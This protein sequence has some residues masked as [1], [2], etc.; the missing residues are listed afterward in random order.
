MRLAGRGET[1][2]DRPP[3]TGE[4][5]PGRAVR[6]GDIVRPARAARPGGG[7]SRRVMT[8]PDWPT[9]SR[10]TAA[11]WPNRVRSTSTSRSRGDRRARG[12][13]AVPAAHAGQVPSSA[14]R[15][16]PG[17]HSGARAAGGL[18]SLPALDVFGVGDDDQVIYQHAG[19]DPA[20]LIDFAVLFPGAVSHPLTVNYRCPVE[21]V[22]AAPDAARLQPSAAWPSEIEQGPG[23]DQTAG[24][25]RDRRARTGRRSPA[26]WPMW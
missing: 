24:A 3:A 13:R 10:S 7:R 25:V 12:G 9:C 14:R 2:A 4:H 16:V 17:P 26:R 6:G 21:V 1:G 11:V 19:A 15:R 18:L 22:V 8:F 5:R 20:F 23:A